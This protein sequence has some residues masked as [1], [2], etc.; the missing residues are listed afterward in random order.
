MTDE[1]KEI[2]VTVSRLPESEIEELEKQIE[3]LHNEHYFDSDYTRMLHTFQ[4][5]VIG[6]GAAWDYVEGLKA[7]VAHLTTEYA[8]E[9][10]CHNLHVTELLNTEKER[11]Q[12]KAGVERYR[13][14]LEFYADITLYGKYVVCEPETRIEKDAG[15]IARKA[16]EG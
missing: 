12:L 11:D 6:Y 15:S 13:K 10:A 9:R 5:L 4:L 7:E 14:A 16:L 8:D 1:L 2:K 3:M